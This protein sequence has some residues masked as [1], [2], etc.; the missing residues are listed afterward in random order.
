LTIQ[1]VVIKGLMTPHESE[2]W[3]SKNSKHYDVESKKIAT[4][5]PGKGGRYKVRILGETYWI[6]YSLLYSPSRGYKF[7]TNGQILARRE[8]AED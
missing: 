4:G 5:M 1:E 2:I 7:S 8:F 6:F 3:Y